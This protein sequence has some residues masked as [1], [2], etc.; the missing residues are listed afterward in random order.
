MRPHQPKG[1]TMTFVIV[2]VAII[3]IGAA[4]NFIGETITR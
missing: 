2:F 3:A 1:T 4:A